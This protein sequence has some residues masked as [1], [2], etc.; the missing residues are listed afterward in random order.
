MIDNDN[1]NSM[2]AV[3]SLCSAEMLD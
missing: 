1:R 2:S 3:A